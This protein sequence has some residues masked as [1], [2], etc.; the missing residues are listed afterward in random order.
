MTCP[1]TL[2]SDGINYK[3]FYSSLREHLEAAVNCHTNACPDSRHVCYKSLP[4]S[5]TIR[6]VIRRSSRNHPV[7]LHESNNFTSSLDETLDALRDIPQ[8]CSEDNWNGFG[9][10]RV[11]P[12]MACAAVNYVKDMYEDPT[13]LRTKDLPCVEPTP[14]GGVSLLYPN[15]EIRFENNIITT[16]CS[17]STHPLV[18]SRTPLR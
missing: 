15:C 1:H 6:E 10:R 5:T 2:S 8:S 12:L 13:G 11:D 4:T 17:S 16:T 7:L 14:G 3:D 18:I 9:A